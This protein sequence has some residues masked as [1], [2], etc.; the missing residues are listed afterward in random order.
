VGFRVYDIA[1]DGHTLWLTGLE[2]GLLVRVDTDKKRI[3]GRIDDFVGPTGVVV[4][5][6]SVW[7]LD[8]RGD[9]LVRIDPQKSKI[10]EKIPLD[11]GSTPE[12][13]TF[14]EGGVWITSLSYSTVSHVDPKT[15][16]A[17]AEI[18][19]GIGLLGVAAGGGSVW[20]TGQPPYCEDGDKG[21]L[22]RID[23]KT[24][25]VVGRT[26]IPCAF[27]VAV[28]DAAVWVNANVKEEGK[29]TSGLV[30]VE[31]TPR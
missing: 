12:G 13:L 30:R 5:A 19:A 29:W 20:A 1:I 14:G 31:P 7:V 24:D 11:V 28:T 17:V 18:E 27:G 16:K 10:V 22:V 15:N 2:E 3:V 25:K 23:P 21:V 26:K 4:G 6:G 8:H 9:A